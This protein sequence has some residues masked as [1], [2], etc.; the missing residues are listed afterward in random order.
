M[1]EKK[2]KPEKLSRSLRRAVKESGKQLSEIVNGSGLRL[3]NLL[4]FLSNDRP[5][6]Q[7]EID[8]LAGY[9][10]LEL[11]ASKRKA[12]QET[13]PG[14]Y[15]ARYHRPLHLKPVLPGTRRNRRST[16]GRLSFL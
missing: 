5:L 16:L 2:A 7:D 6:L 8:A 14:D 13:R 3:S 1:P 4:R 11:V 9:L 10:G 15:L 12:T